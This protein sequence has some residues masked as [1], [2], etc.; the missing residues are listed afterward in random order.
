MATFKSNMAQGKRPVPSLNDT[1]GVKIPYEI[2]LPTAALAANDILV[3]GP[4]EANVRPLD[5]DLITDKLDSNGAP[6]IVLS[7]GILNADLTDIDAAA[8]S[9]WI[10]GST[11]GQNGG[12]TR[13][14]TPNALLSLRRSTTRQLGVKV[15]TAPATYA[16]AGKQLV[17]LV[18]CQ[19]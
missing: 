5:V 7:V 8:T 4:L 14:T 18:T 3:L 19:G 1:L 13:A 6:A 11:A 2:I 10:A 17:V 15:V 9:T 12:I 16:G